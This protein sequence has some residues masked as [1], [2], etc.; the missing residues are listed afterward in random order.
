MRCAS[1]GKFKKLWESK[2]PWKT[3]FFKSHHVRNIKKN[4]F[5]NKWFRIGSKPEFYSRAR[6][7]IFNL[8][9]LES[10]LKP[11]VSNAKQDKFPFIE[12]RTKQFEIYFISLN[13]FSFST[14]T[15]TSYRCNRYLNYVNFSHV[16]YSTLF[17]KIQIARTRYYKQII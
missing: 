13:F 14:A 6:E 8:S 3:P 17:G 11:R 5:E 4:Y 7:I 9:F 1:I 2:I 15:R 12:D 16:I 10:R